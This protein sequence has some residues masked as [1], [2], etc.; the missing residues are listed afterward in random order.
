MECCL[1]TFEGGVMFFFYFSFVLESNVP[2]ADLCLRFLVKTWKNFFVIAIVYLHLTRCS[3]VEGG[4]PPISLDAEREI[5]ASCKLPWSLTDIVTLVKVQKN[6]QEMGKNSVCFTS[7]IEK[8]V[9]TPPG[10]RSKRNKTKTNALL[11]FPISH[12]IWTQMK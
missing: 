7:P 5:L 12:L 1:N 2:L 3:C 10:S 8:P 11:K 6:A 9:L 4:V